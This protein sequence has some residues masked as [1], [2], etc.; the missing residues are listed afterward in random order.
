[1]SSSYSSCIDLFICL[2]IIQSIVIIFIIVICPQHYT[3]LRKVPK[4][5]IRRIYSKTIFPISFCTKRI[6]FVIYLTFLKIIL[7]RSNLN[8]FQEQKS[9]S[10]DTLFECLYFDSFHIVKQPWDSEQNVMK[11]SEWQNVRSACSHDATFSQLCR[12]SFQSIRL[13]LISLVH[14]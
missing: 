5:S 13:Q 8:T 3:E 1:M 12:Y 9:M 2:S 14:R 7:N 11:K 10:R 4:Q 6:P